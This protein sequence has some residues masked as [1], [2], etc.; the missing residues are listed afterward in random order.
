VAHYPAANAENVSLDSSS[1]LY[2]SELM[3]ESLNVTRIILEDSSGQHLPGN[4][5]WSD[6]L[7]LNFSPAQPLNSNTKYNVK[8]YRDLATDLTGNILK[9]S[10]ISF[11]FK[12]MDIEKTGSLSGSVKFTRDKFLGKIFLDLTGLDNKERYRHFLTSGEAFTFYQVMPGSYILSGFVDF[13][14]NGAYS[15]GNFQPFTLAEPF[16]IYPDTI[17]VR[18]RWT[19]EG[20]TLEF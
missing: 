11:N 3:G 19:T 1:L 14:E 2:F 16:A 17:L 5:S 18:S 7:T 9:D 20:I 4:L 13:D 10:L 6:D 15:F 12:T 8:I